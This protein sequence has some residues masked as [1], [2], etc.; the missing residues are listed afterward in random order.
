[1]GARIEPC[2]TPQESLA[3]N[4]E[5]LPN[6]TEKLLFVKYDMSM[7]ISCCFHLSD[8]HDNV[9]D[10]I[11]HTKLA[12]A[13]PPKADDSWFAWL[14]LLWVGW[15]YWLIHTCL[16]VGLGITLLIFLL[17]CCL[18]CFSSLIRKAVTTTITLVDMQRRPDNEYEMPNLHPAPSFVPKP[19]VYDNID[20]T[21][22][23]TE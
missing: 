9:T 15:G 21:D 14:T 7:S 17:P 3:G 23:D 2:G 10:L 16:P 18:R 22:S 4:E 8:Y 11:N 6:L 13:T 19:P 20:F 1:M 12:I 5:K